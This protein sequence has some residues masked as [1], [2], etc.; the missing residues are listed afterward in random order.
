MSRSTA[1]LVISSA[2]PF[3]G[4]IKDINRA[5]RAVNFPGLG[6]PIV[7]SIVR[8]R[9]PLPFRDADINQVR[10]EGVLVGICDGHGSL[11]TLI[12]GP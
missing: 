2:Q 5:I 4:V 12:Y 11:V 7:R 6:E 9:E 3:G 10:R 1:L 8:F